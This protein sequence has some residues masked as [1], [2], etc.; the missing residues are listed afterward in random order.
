ML[1]LQMGQLFNM[2]QSVWSHTRR[3]QIWRKSDP[4]LVSWCPDETSTRTIKNYYQLQICASDS[5]RAVWK[6]SLVSAKADALRLPHHQKRIPCS[7]LLN[8]Y[9]STLLP[10]R[11]PLGCSH[12]AP[13]FGN[14]LFRWKCLQI[15]HQSAC[16][17]VILV[18]PLEN[19]TFC[20][21]SWSPLIY[22]ECHPA[23]DAKKTLHGKLDVGFLC[24]LA[25]SSSCRNFPYW[26]CDWVAS[27]QDSALSRNV[28]VEHQFLDSHS[29]LNG[30]HLTGFP[31]PAQLSP[32]LAIV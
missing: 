17:P 10:P 8:L 6:S 7:L 29:G 20:L 3:K 16:S 30:P 23:I 11:F 15:T 18:S 22:P 9:N 5:V 26:Y 32:T 27:E 12:L 19:M 1:G 2:M 25:A 28:T 24:K 21:F 14:V 4:G 13:L 31:T